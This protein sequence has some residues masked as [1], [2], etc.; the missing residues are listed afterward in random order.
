MSIISKLK[1]FLISKEYN[2]VN[3]LEFKNYDIIIFNHVLMYFK[4]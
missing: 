1:K 2:E 4:R 3:K